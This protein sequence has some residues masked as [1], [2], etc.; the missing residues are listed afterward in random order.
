MNIHI[1]CYTFFLLNYYILYSRVFCEENDKCVSKSILEIILNKKVYLHQKYRA[2][3][4]PCV[5]LVD[6]NERARM[7]KRLVSILLYLTNLNILR[8]ERDFG[9]VHAFSFSFLLI[10]HTIYLLFKYGYSPCSMSLI[11]IL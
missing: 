5:K 6:K 2:W 3:T 7:W 1:F 4:M 9:R 8:R 11:Y 10:P